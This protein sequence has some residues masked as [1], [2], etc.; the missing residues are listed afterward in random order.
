MQRGYLALTGSDAVAEVKQCFTTGV[1]CGGDPEAREN[2]PSKSQ[3]SS[4]RCSD[5]SLKF[6]L[7]RSKFL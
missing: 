1:N 2:R 3:L 4:N 6:L 7:I 5:S